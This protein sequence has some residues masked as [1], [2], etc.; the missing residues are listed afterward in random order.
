M[1]ETRA[2]IRMD[3]VA[4]VDDLRVVV[5]DLDEGQRVPWHHH[6]EITDHFICMAGPMTISMRDPDDVVRLEAGDSWTVAPK[7]PHE[8]MGENG[9]ACRFAIVQGVGVYDY[10]RDDSTLSKRD[11]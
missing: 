10:V 8:V 7:R 11:G 6:S 3:V 5:L 9:R 1:A 4:S 2:A